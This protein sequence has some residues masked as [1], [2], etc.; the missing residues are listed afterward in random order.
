MTG[1]LLHT[2]KATIPFAFALATFLFAPDARAQDPR[3][4]EFKTHRYVLTG[5]NDVYVEMDPEFREFLRSFRSALSNKNVDEVMSMTHFP[6]VNKYGIRITED[7]FEDEFEMIFHEEA[8][9]AFRITL[10]EWKIE[11]LGGEEVYRKRIVEYDHFTDTLNLGLVDT[12]VFQFQLRY[13]MEYYVYFTRYESGLN[14]NFYKT[15]EGGYKIFS[16]DLV[17]VEKE[18]AQEAAEANESQP[19]DSTNVSDTT[20]TDLPP[21]QP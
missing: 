18:E 9:Q 11:Y 16:V 1:K 19:P 12:T 8:I 4:D 14:F 21:P 2:A 3:D 10:D 6:F 13:S 7:E 17:D 20:G 5:E 15:P